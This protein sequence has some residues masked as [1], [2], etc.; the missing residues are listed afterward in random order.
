MTQGPGTNF[1]NNTE[2]LITFTDDVN[3]DN[4]YLIDFGFNKFVVSSDEFYKGKQHTISYIYD[5]ELPS[6]TEVTVSLMGIDRSFF[7]YMTKLLEQSDDE[8]DLF[9]TPVST[10][11]G[12]I[13]NVTEIDNIDFFDNVTQTNNFALGY[14]AVAET[15]T[16]TIVIE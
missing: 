8:I 13:I 15:Y 6:G 5:R 2:V 4:F 7:N 1:D 16:K 12:N 11:R 14:Y 10:L 3:D 9:Q